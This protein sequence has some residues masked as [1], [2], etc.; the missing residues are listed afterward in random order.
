LHRKRVNQPSHIE[1]KIK[2]LHI[3]RGTPLTI[4]SPL[5][6]EDE[7]E[8]EE[9][10]NHPS[11]IEREKQAPSHRKR[12]MKERGVKEVMERERRKSSKREG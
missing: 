3:E 4:T 7:G 8:G 2:S 6:G 9:I 1:S 5:G 12:R 10:Q 11:C